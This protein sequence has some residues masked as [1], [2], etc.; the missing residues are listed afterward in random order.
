VDLP[1]G[2]GK[3]LLGNMHAVLDKIAGGWQLS[4]IGTIR[5]NHFALPTGIYPT[6]G[7]P[8]EIYGYEY[9]SRTAAAASA[10]PATC[11]G[12]ATSPRTRSTAWMPPASR[13]ASWAFGQL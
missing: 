7:N 13:T 1:I 10:N 6:T 12:T 5:S 11:G 9:P 8:I 2:Q 4:G 3:P